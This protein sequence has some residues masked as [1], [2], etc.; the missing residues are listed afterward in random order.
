MRLEIGNGPTSEQCEVQ[1][2]YLP[3]AIFIRTGENREAMICHVRMADGRVLNGSSVC[4]PP[5]V[6]NDVRGKK[7]AFGRAISGE[8]FEVRERLWKAYLLETGVPPRFNDVAPLHT[9]EKDLRVSEEKKASEWAKLVLTNVYFK[10]DIADKYC[11]AILALEKLSET[12]KFDI[13]E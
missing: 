11:Q 4:H 10:K 12:G 9:R 1:F 6:F 5:D 7:I 3:G 13:H 2:K 8:P